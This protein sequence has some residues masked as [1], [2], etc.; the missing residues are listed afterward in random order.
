MEQP[1][2]PF[3]RA[4][5]TMNREVETLRNLA[6]QLRDTQPEEAAACMFAAGVLDSLLQKWPR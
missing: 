3:V 4:N 1:L 2:D 5:R 6:N